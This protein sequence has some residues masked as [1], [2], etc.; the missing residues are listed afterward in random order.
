M[1]WNH[2]VM[3]HIDPV[4]KEEWLDI[5]EVYYHKDGQHHSYTK[6]AIDPCGSNIGELRWVLT[7][8]LE[9]LDKPVLTEEDFPKGS[10]F[11]QEP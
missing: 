2:R 9:C 11:G 10:E 1:S 3:K 5:H 6:D 4:N 7:K 8:M